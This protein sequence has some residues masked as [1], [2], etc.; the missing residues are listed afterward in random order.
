MKTR[1]MLAKSQQADFLAPYLVRFEEKKPLDNEID[2]AIKDCLRDFKKNH[3]EMI[4]EPQRRY[5]ESTA[6]LNSLKRFLQRH[7]E[8]FSVQDYE[9]FIEEG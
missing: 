4:N 8:Q 6:E 1:E 9:K 3:D 7:M 2:A 5:D